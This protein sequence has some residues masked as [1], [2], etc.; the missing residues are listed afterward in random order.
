ML[1]RC[2]FTHAI[3]QRIVFET[4]VID[5]GNID[6]RFGGHQTERLQQ[7]EVFL[8][9][10]HRTHRIAFVQLGTHFL[11]QGAE[12]NRLLVTGLGGFSCT[13]YRFL[14]GVEIGQREFRM[15]GLDIGNRVYLARDVD[16]VVVDEA[17]H[18]VDDAVGF[19]NVGE[20]LVTQALTL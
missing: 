19:P 8:I 9:E 7:H 2:V 14:N 16:H 3:E 18:H 6:R 15:D 20:E 11:Q 12:A 4:L 1:L 13:L 10:L 5:V 17:A